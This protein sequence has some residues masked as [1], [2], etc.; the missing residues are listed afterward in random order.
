MQNTCVMTAD[1]LDQLE[2]KK[3]NRQKV[4]FDFI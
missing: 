1:D 4:E 3:K 2:G